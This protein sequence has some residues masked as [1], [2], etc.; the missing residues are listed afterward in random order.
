[1]VWTGSSPEPLLR[2]ERGLHW[3]LRRTRD[4]KLRRAALRRRPS[5]AATATANDRTT[6]SSVDVPFMRSLR[7]PPEHRV[8]RK[9]VPMHR[10]YLEQHP[11]LQGLQQGGVERGRQEAE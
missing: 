6:G 9:P 10:R 7:G 8:P 3:V 5:D 11:P 2:A 4:A 1:M